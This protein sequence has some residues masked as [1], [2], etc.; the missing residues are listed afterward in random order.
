M[1]NTMICVI[2]LLVL[3]ILLFMGMNIGLAMLTVGFFGY[4]AVI[5]LRAALIILSTVPYSV[6]DT[7]SYSVIG[8]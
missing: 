5:N 7:Y 4:A 2:G 1:T 6:A 3:M 8:L